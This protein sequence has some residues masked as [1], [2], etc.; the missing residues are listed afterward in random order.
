MASI[1]LGMRIENNKH[2]ISIARL[3]SSTVIYFSTQLCIDLL[4]YYILAVSEW[5]ST[6]VNYSLDQGIS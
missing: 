5:V 1:S 2:P 6:P 3:T 4:C